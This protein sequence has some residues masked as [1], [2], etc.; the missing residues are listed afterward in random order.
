MSTESGNI[1]LLIIKL[2]DLIPDGDRIVYL[3]NNYVNFNV[4]TE[5]KESK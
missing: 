2:A 5:E 1:S 4:N 3:D